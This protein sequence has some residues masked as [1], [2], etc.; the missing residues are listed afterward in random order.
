MSSGQIALAQINP[1]LGDLEGNA[2]LIFLAAKE[3]FAKGAKVLLTPE[4]SLTGYPPEDLLLRP[5]FIEAC[6]RTL[7][8]LTK[9][10][11]QLAG[12]T[13]VIG[14]PQKSTQGLQNAAS[15]V[16]DG[17][18]IASYAKQELPNHEVFD[19]VRYFTPGN[20]PCVFEAGGLRFGLILCEDAW[21]AG[22]AQQAHAAGAQ[23]LLVANASP[24]H[25]NKEALRI[26]V[27]REH[28]ALTKMPLIYVNAVGGQD[29]LVFDGGSFA[30]N[31]AA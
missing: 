15:V 5:A 30:L 24:Y 20:T 21:H 11:A 6:D 7:Q 28:I 9:S 23:V 22:P 17:K 2:E 4:L 25:L 13:V 31:S 1:L 26:E 27:L 29:E 8:A 10:L 19:E 14:H 16:R 3:A 12:L 18:V